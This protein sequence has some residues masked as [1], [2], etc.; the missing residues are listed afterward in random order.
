MVALG[1][2]AINEKML[3]R[4]VKIV[5][6]GGGIGNQMFSYA[7]G[8]ALREATGNKVVYK[9]R[10]PIEPHENVSISDKVFVSFQ[11][12]FFPEVSSVS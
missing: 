12:F 11:Q 3:H 8:V 4:N 7:F 1:S 10:A 6:A 9:K 2:F 5:R